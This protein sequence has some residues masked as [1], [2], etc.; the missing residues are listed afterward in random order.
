MILE[1]ATLPI[2]IQEQ[3]THLK[4]GEQLII[5]NQGRE[6]TSA[7]VNPSYEKGDFDYDLQR[8]KQAVEAP[9]ITVPRFDTVEELS[10]WLDNLTDAD[11][12]ER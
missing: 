3:I 5:A 1:L 8:M 2:A 10:A 9:R 6:I 4:A 12:V 11:F 7:T